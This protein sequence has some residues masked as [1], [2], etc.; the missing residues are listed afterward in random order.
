LAIVVAIIVAG[1]AMF[2]RSPLHIAWT[3]HWKWASRVVALVWAFAFN[4]GLFRIGLSPKERRGLPLSAGA[5]IAAILQTITGSLYIYSIT[6]LGDG[7]AYLAGLATIGVT[8]TALFLYTLFLLVGLSVSQFL[9][10]ASRCKRVSM[11]RKTQMMRRGGS[12]QLRPEG[13]SPI[14][15]T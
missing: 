7:G 4:R 12:R 15:D 3:G 11:I 13:N 1:G 8:L 14:E 2:A 6:L 5:A 9:K 10:R